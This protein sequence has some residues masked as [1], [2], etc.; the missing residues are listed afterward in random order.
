MQFWQGLILG[1][2]LGWIIEWII[3]WWYWRGGSGGSS[4]STSHG[5]DLI[6]ITGINSEY[7][8]K[9]SRSGISSVATLANKTPSVV[10]SAI[11][12][13]DGKTID[14]E[15]WIAEAGDLTGKSSGDSSDST[16]GLASL[17]TATESTSSTKPASSSTTSSQPKTSES[18]TAGSGSTSSKSGMKPSGGSTPS[19]S[20]G[21]SGTGSTK[22]SSGG[23]SATGAATTSA[24][25]TSAATTSA[26]SLGST[27]TVKPSG[28]VSS[29]GSAT[30]STPSG[31]SS[32]GVSSSKPS[33]SS[34]A[35]ASANKGSTTGSAQRRDDLT[36][37][38]GVGKVF[39]GKFYD[40]GYTTWESVSKLSDE[41][42][43]RV[44]QPK[45]WQKIETDVWV[46]E[47]RILA[48]G[49]TTGRE[50]E[51]SGSSDDG[52]D[53]TKIHGIGKVYQGKFHDAGVYLWSEV[54]ELSDEKILA[55]IEPAEWQKI[56]PEE[57]KAEARQFVKE[58]GGDA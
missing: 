17:S 11:G 53:L 55:I 1:L 43:R 29:T 44:I 48:G 58:K 38:H 9:L 4:L 21:A 42:I 51:S 35:S 28:G 12:G 16:S 26:A 8:D 14:A 13:D 27:S 22:P 34:S 2:I 20:T 40:A 54:A 57:W 6:R 52:D 5:S 7:A 47:A 23:T 18:S 25:T 10:R 15:A 50:N 19:S 32:S 33:A 41:E 36:K 49:G 37:I 45:D 30:P 24:A 56:E 3:D 31:V 46:E 39:Q